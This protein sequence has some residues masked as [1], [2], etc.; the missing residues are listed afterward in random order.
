[1]PAEEAA[2]EATEEA[3]GEAT[4]MPAEEATEEAM[5]EATAMPAEEATE[6]AMGEATAMPM[7]EGTPMPVEPDGGTGATAGATVMAGGND[8][9]GEFV[10]DS[11]GMTLYMFDRDEPPI[12]NCYDDCATRWPPL[13]VAEGEQP[14][15]GE[16][17][18]GVLGVTERTDGTLQVTFNDWPLYY[19]WEDVQPGDSLGQ[20]VGDVW[21]VMAP[22]GTIIR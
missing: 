1:M 12:S 8:E 17:V 21:W 19:W 5:G 22:D 4:A 14:T 7:E 11:A 9:L 2:G 16:G 3:A 10:V 20:A 6:E 15:A 18:T 13:L